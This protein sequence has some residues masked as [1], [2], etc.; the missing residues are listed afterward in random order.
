M[1]MRPT[2]S[3]IL[4]ALSVWTCG[5]SVFATEPTA[6]RVMTFN[7]LHGGTERGQP[8]SQSAEVMKLA[9]VVGI[10]ETHAEQ[11]DNSVKL[12]K[13]LGWHHFQQGGKTAVV[14]RYPITGHTPNRW[15]VYIKV[16][17][18]LTVCLF[19]VHFPASPYQPYQLLGIP[20]G[21][22]VPFI[23]TESEAI[24]WANRSRGAELGRMLKELSVVHERGTPIFVTGDFNEPSFQDWTQP[25]ADAGVHP[26][27]VTYPAT[28]R[29]TDHGMIDS[30]RELHRNELQRPGYTWTPL[31]E[32]SDQL[33]HHDRID[34]VFA[35]NRYCDIE[36]C[37]VVG[38]NEE[39]ADIVVTPWPSD[40]RAV[41]ATVKVELSE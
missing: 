16:A 21:D 32:T 31:T 30:Y 35:D 14:S 20:Y 8:L 7:I 38:E 24:D 3:A 1:I 15:G 40:H 26:I 36:S 28:K 22:D 13:L 12:A 2:T 11:T 23:K 9:D 34:F 39:S 25:A 27:K 6:L 4:L 10:Q 18:D 5:G 33:D 19:N 17:G 37:Q 29:V 41:L